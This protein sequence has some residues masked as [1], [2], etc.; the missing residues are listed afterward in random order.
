MD[1][2]ATLMRAKAKL[3]P[4]EFEN[5]TFLEP[6]RLP[7]YPKGPDDHD[8]VCGGGCWKV[9]LPG[10]SAATARTVFGEG[11]KRLYIICPTC[12]VYNAVPAVT[13]R[14]PKRDD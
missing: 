8:F 12:G 9:V 3:S 10:Y 14:P 7:L 4:R 2:K 6:A 5:A 1:G 11:R 13:A